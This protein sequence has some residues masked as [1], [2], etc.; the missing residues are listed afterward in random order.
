MKKVIHTSILSVIIFP[1]FINSTLAAFTDII[2][3]TTFYDAIVYVQDEGI[4]SGFEDGT[5]RPLNEI[6]RGEFTKIIINSRFDQS[7][8]ENCTEKVFPDI[9][10]ENKFI[11]Y[12]CVAKNH[13]IVNGYSD[14]NYYSESTISVA[15]AMKILSNSF[16]LELLNAQ[17]T[18]NKFKPYVDS[19]SEVNA[20]PGTIFS[21]F[22][23]LLRDEMAEF[24][25]RLENNYTT[26]PSLS[27]EE[28]NILYD[29]GQIDSENNTFSEEPVGEE[30]KLAI[31][32]VN[33]NTIS[34][35]ET[36]SVAENYKDLQNDTTKHVELWTLFAS[37][38]P[39]ERRDFLVEYILFT[40]GEAEAL[41]TVHQSQT[42]LSKWV[43][44][45]D[46][47]DSYYPDFEF[48]NEED[49][50]FTLIHEYAH[51]LTLNSSQLSVNSLDSDCR[52]THYVPEG[53]SLEES[54]L[55]Q[56]VSQFWTDSMINQVQSIDLIEDADAYYDAIIEFYTNHPNSFVSEYAATNEV[57]DLA[58][59]FTFF[60]L[61]DRPT[62]S[63]TADQKILFFYNYPELIE[64]REHMRSI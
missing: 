61:Q 18:E 14:G 36:P 11:R 7:T 20:I 42:D 60:V 26:F 25:Y 10:D 53:C 59:S 32:E 8:I 1:L 27:Y 4:V 47:Y 31:Y 13:N 51:L 54:Y 21:M 45:I 37:L 29:G 58:E 56:F 23:P 41:A 52:T 49:V 40:D 15:E 12:I 64:L 48:M 9:T 38:I 44:N 24:I 63:T 62:G 16:D 3:D 28:I 17:E 5:Y 57:E 19:L 50:L 55:N 46:I 22:D 39:L 35:K 30:N 2:P 33:N 43:L 6:T 34:L